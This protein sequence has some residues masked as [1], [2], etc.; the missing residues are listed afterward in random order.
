MEDAINHKCSEDNVKLRD[1]LGWGKFMA[2]TE[3]CLPVEDRS[4]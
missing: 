1:D 3:R 2:R 4:S